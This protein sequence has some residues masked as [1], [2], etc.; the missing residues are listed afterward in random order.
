MCAPYT[1]GTKLSSL[2]LDGWACGA[3][4]KTDSIQEKLGLG[5]QRGRFNLLGFGYLGVR[6][7]VKRSPS[8]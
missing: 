5:L 2:F 4:T 8:D 7:K 1:T 3:G 6:F